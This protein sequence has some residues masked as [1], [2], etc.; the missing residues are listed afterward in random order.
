MQT[1]IRLVGITLLDQHQLFRID[2]TLSRDLMYCA[3]L[4]T[5][6]NAFKVL[7]STLID[8]FLS[9]LGLANQLLAS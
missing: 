1:G 9:M 6:S 5:S 7:S 8:L 4:V 3:K 2:L